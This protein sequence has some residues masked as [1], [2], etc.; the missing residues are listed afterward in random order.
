MQHTPHNKGPVRTVPDAADQK[1]DQDIAV[2]V[3]RGA[4]AA[5]GEV[6]R[7]EDVIPQPVC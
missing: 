3:E 7:N 4:F 5:G 1:D 2:L 6:E